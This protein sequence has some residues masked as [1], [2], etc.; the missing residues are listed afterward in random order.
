MNK[1]I[2]VAAMLLF[3]AV[4]SVPTASAAD[5]CKTHGACVSVSGSGVFVGD[6]RQ[7]TC[8]GVWWG[9]GEV[10]FGF[11]YQVPQCFIIS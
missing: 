5:Y 9:N 2:L 4:A 7:L 3:V 6:C 11:S 8:A 1:T 10:C